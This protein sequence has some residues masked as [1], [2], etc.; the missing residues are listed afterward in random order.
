MPSSI[1]LRTWWPLLP[2][3]KPSAS[4]TSQVRLIPSPHC[5]CNHIVVVSTTTAY[6]HTSVL[7]VNSIS[8]CILQ[9]LNRANFRMCSAC[10]CRVSYR[11]WGALESPPPPPPRKLENLYSLIF[12]H[13]AVAVPYMYKL[14]PLPPKFLYETL[15]WFATQSV[16]V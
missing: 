5:R 11:G 3:T 16:H 7:V 10:T 12:M 15:T 2:S 4:G 13:D 6:Q 8:D 9:F 1:P 14:L